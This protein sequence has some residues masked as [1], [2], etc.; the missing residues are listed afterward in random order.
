M[1]RITADQARGFNKLEKSMEPIYSAIR[2]QVEKQR[3]GDVPSSVYV[4]RLSCEQINQLKKDGFDVIEYG[5]TEHTTK[6]DC[7]IEW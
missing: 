3:H 5:E 2:D 4:E 6:G 1:N 7:S